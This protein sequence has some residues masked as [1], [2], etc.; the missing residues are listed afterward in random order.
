MIAD[1]KY[2]YILFD[3]ILM[4]EINQMLNKNVIIGL[5]IFLMSTIAMSMLP[6]NA[7]AQYYERGRKIRRHIPG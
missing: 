2:F 5:T 7:A 3:L 1:R 4:V 6:F